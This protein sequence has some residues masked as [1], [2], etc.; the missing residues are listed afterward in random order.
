MSPL[1]VFLNGLIA[2]ERNYIVVFVDAVNQLSGNAAL[3]SITQSNIA[4]RNV[5]SAVKE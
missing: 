1:M 2:F 5:T 3:S 4:S